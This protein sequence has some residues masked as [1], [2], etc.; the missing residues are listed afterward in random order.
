MVDRSQTFHGLDALRGIAAIVVLT[1]HAP[2]FFGAGLFQGSG[3]GVD[4]FFAMSGFV[5]AHAYDGRILGGLSVGT[6]MRI[7]LIRL[8]P[9]YILGTLIGILVAAASISTG[10][11]STR[12]G[13]AWT[14]PVF[15]ES[16]LS[17]LFLLPAPPIDGTEGSLYPLNA[18]AWSLLFEIIVNFVYVL[19]WRHITNARLVATMAVSGAALVVCGF[20]YQNL[21]IGWNWHTWPGGLA[22]VFYSFPAGVLMYRLWASGQLR[23]KGPFWLP[24]LATV[25]LMALRMPENWRVAYDI[26][27]ILAI[28]PFVT[29]MAV[30]AAFPARLVTLASVL[31]LTSYAV[32]ALHRPVLSVVNGMAQVARIDLQAYAPWSGLPFLVVFILGC[33]LID[34]LYDAP[35]RR[36]LSKRLV[37]RP[38]PLAVSSA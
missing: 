15:G 33:W 8:Y 19:V 34:R 31:G 38:K 28:F 27:V 30:Q 7:R 13:I 10:V 35:V 2:S 17:S 25:T 4:L 1:R 3:L 36:A 12:G 29:V 14:L 22:R 26:L 21:D 16:V 32:Y 5:I 20:A 18:V 37:K 24:L 23:L 9:L 11:Q 6:F